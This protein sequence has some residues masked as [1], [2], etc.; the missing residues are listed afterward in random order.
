MALFYVVFLHDLVYASQL[1]SIALD[2]ANI[3]HGEA[4]R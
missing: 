4:V 2:M 1:I 3:F